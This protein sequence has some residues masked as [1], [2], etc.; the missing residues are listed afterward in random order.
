[1]IITADAGTTADWYGQ[2]IKLGRGMDGSLSGSLASM[3]ASMPY[4]LSAKFAH[5]GRPVVCTIGDGAFQ[6]LGMNELLTVKRYWQEWEDPRFIVLVLHN[7]DLTQ[8]S[9]EMREAGDPRYDTSQEVE[10]MDYAAFA[11]V[12]GLT[13]IRVDSKDEVAGAWDRAFAA[14][15]PVVL[16]VRT[17]PNT[18]PLP[19]HISLDEAKGMAASLAKGDPAEGSVISQSARGMAAA[20][21]TKAKETLHRDG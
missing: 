15:R 20:L 2:H 19:P 21:F 3:L 7:N 11:D 8:V 18:P 6:M 13:G 10:D 14:D 4:A 1:M 16:D 12:L 17:D 5:P 9:W